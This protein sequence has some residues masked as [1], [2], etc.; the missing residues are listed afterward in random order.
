MTTLACVRCGH[1]W[2]CHHRWRVTQ[3]EPDYCDYPKGN[4]NCGCTA[5]MSD[6]EGKTLKQAIEES[7]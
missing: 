7:R 5:F 2:G 1:S 3:Y 4:A 6:D